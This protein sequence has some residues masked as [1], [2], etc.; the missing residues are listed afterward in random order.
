LKIGAEVSDILGRS[1]LTNTHLDPAT[2]PILACTFAYG[3]AAAPGVD[4]YMARDLL[5]VS[6]NP[7]GTKT[8]ESVVQDRGAGTVLPLGD[9]A[10]F[11][12]GRTIG[13]GQ[14]SGGQ[15]SVLHGTTLI[16]IYSWFQ[17]TPPQFDSSQEQL[18]NVAAKVLESSQN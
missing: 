6:V 11:Y 13:N 7:E 15:V 4:D 9:E 3:A 14:A 10:H 12:E 18:V 1:T 5:T 8:F 2:S 16:T 17:N